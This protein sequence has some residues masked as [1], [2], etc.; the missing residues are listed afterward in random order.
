MVPSCCIGEHQN[1]AVATA[2]MDYGGYYSLWI[3]R[4]RLSMFAERGGMNSIA[5]RTLV[6]R[7]YG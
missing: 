4:P 5:I 3:S 7:S 2:W 1:G 6:N